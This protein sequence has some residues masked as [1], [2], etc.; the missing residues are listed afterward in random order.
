MVQAKQKY[1]TEPGVLEQSPSP[2][3]TQIMGT[4][5]LP[6]EQAA[7][8][9]SVIIAGD[10]EE[11]SVQSSQ[12]N[13]NAKTGQAILLAGQT[14]MTIQNHNVAL[15]KNIILTTEG[16]TQNRT[17]SLTSKKAA[18]DGVIGWF[19]V[20]VDRPATVDIKF[21]WWIVD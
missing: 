18:K 9:S 14:E 21:T 1:L 6:L 19:K 15:N 2:A 17:L 7:K 4:E 8:L 3:S 12:I 20:G 11:N 5:E 16:E 13:L 10:K